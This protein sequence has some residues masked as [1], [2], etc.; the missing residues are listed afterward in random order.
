MEGWMNGW[1]R[2]YL[3]DAIHVLNTVLSHWGYSSEQYRRKSLSWWDVQFMNWD[4]KGFSGICERTVY[5]SPCDSRLI[6]WKTNKLTARFQEVWMWVP[7]PNKEEVLVPT[8][9][10]FLLINPQLPVVIQGNWLVVLFGRKKCQRGLNS[11]LGSKSK[12]MARGNRKAA[13][14]KKLWRRR[15]A[16]LS[17]Q[18]ISELKCLRCMQV[19]FQ[20]QD[21]H[22]LMCIS[23]YKKSLPR[24]SHLI[25]WR[26][27]PGRT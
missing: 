20:Y 1:L 16:Y 2:T 15:F 5:L 19:L 24:S 3:L 11:F 27:L 26:T 9:N 12:V 18:V 22:I 21:N 7:P 10:H 17:S 25:L 8:L 13:Y 23:L 6:W 4:R 14:T